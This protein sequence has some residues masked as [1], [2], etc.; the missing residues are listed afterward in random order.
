[1]VKKILSRTGIVILILLIYLFIFISGA[2]LI[3]YKGGFSS[4]KD[5]VTVTLM[6]TSAAK[7]IPE[8]FLSKEELEQIMALNTVKETDVEQN[9]QLVTVQENIGS[10]IELKEVSGTTFK[11]RML[12][13]KDPK[14][15]YVATPAVFE[16]ASGGLKVEEMVK[17]DNAAAGVN[18]GGF[19]DIN[20]VGNG[21]KPIGFVIKNGEIVF[22]TKNT[23]AS[24]VGFDSVGKLI[25]GKMTAEEALSKDVVDGLTFDPVGALI[26]NGK[27]LDIKGTG[28]G[29]NPR[30]AIGQ[31]KD[32]SILLL[33][34]DGRQ[35]HSL[36][37]SFKD[38][39]EIFTE[40]E[41]VTAANLD[42]GSSSLMVYNDEIISVTASL[43]G[44]RKLPTAILVRGK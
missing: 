12:I 26:V 13:I 28:G 43:Y 5:L 10:E 17:R 15:L 27:P 36:G 20:G 3:C 29:L 38:L 24:L 23:K 25:V 1:M 2:V 42:G 6:E 34:I 8:M 30:T 22:G 18:G 35:S 41:A 4:A 21:G 39:I 32:G 31:R 7:F 11:G 40:Y 16:T 33:V 19:E 9:E 44:S 37:A 14:R